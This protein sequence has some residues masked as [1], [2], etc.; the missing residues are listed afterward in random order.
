MGSIS[1]FFGNIIA[2]FSNSCTSETLE[3]KLGVLP[4]L[5]IPKALNCVGTDQKF[6]SQTFYE[7]FLG[8]LENVSSN[9]QEVIYVDIENLIRSDSSGIAVLIHGAGYLNR[10][11][12]KLCLV[13][14]SKHVCDSIELLGVRSKQI[15]DIIRYDCPKEITSQ[16][17]SNVYDMTREYVNRMILATEE[18]IIRVN[19]NDLE[20]ID[21]QGIVSIINVAKELKK[22]NRKLGLR[23]LKEEIKAV[24]YLAGYE[25]MNVVIL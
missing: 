4:K 24:F 5:E 7:K 19:M 13:N 15:L 20:N 3:T 12:K 23:N 2:G 18:Q 25:N 10:K 11:G 16:N 6:S 1:G 14:P 22:K 21:E 17:A 8:Y 9:G